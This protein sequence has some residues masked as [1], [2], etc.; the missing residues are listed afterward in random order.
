MP[1]AKQ[2]RPR[3]FTLVE[4]LVVIAIIGILVALLLPAVQA[5][6]EAARRTH[7]S[8]NLKQIGLA[9]QNYHGTRKTFP[10]GSLIELVGRDEPSKTGWSIELLP[11]MEEPALY[12]LFNPKVSI[13]DPLNQLLRESPA[14]AFTCPSDL[15]GALLVPESGPEGGWASLRGQRQF[16]TGSYRGNAG[17]VHEYALPGGPPVTP[18]TYP[19]WYLA[20]D[21]RTAAGQWLIPNGWR[22]PLHATGLLGLKPESISKITDGTSKTLMVGENTSITRPERRSFWAY[23]WGGYA[24]SQAWNSPDNFSAD[25]EACAAKYTGEKPAR[26]CHSRW[27]SFHPSTV[28]FVRCDGSVTGVNQD[29]DLGVFGGLCSIAGEELNQEP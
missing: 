19:T 15:P 7:C 2:I 10:P 17:R 12:A 25:F 26:M 16:Y 11:Y 27:Y 24:M 29:I 5:A 9:A 18:T 1:S 28:N 6:R 23:T 20:E 4:L 8:N 13:G 21:V 22:G 3:A 14:P